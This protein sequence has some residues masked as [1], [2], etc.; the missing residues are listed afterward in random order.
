[1][2]FWNRRESRAAS[3][4]LAYPAQWLTEGFSGGSAV[5]GQRVTV[6]NALGV[7]P[8]WAAVSMIS[9]QVGQLPLKVYKMVDG[10]RVEARN[11][12]AWS[13]LHD[14]PN[15]YTPADRFWSAVTVHLLL[16]GNA[17]I[18]KHRDSLGLVDELV[19]MNPS[20]IIVY[21]D[22]DQRIKQF[23]Y[24]PLNGQLQILGPE[25]VVH[26]YGMSTDG[27]IGESVIGKCKNAFGAAMARE[28]YEGGFY[29]RGA[30]LSAVV[31]MDDQIKN[32][33]ALKRLKESVTALFSGSDKAHG[34][35]V[36]E[37]GAKF[38]TVGSVMKDLQFVESQ[39]LSRTDIAVM[40]KLPPNY[41]GGSSGDSLTYST[42]ESN[43]IAFALHAISPWT[44]TIAKALT[45]DPSIFPQNV[46][47]AEFSID[48]M[49]RADATAR[50]DYYTKMSAIKA[51]TTNEIR[52]L[53]N[54]PPVPGGD[55][56]APPQADRVSVTEQAP[57]GDQ[58]LPDMSSNGVGP[59]VQN[60]S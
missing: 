13:L 45:A 24:R 33:M 6:K 42:V 30:T 27:V 32:D 55:E 9:E 39:Q 26:I 34:V 59:G 5:S 4:G 51:M 11:H 36:F 58:E 48:G 8:V 57:V 56:F 43:Q 46:Y 52:H 25:D 10:D 53:E 28:E 29:K 37:N 31:E 18:R 38:R 1:L 22:G 16:Y 41:L 35:G 50:A 12:R 2:A 7:A 40:F 3:S 14:K 21:W 47:D 20:H 23:N 15:E 60:G 44:N 54:L 49:L 19:L 17:F